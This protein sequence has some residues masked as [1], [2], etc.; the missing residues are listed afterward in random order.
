MRSCPSEAV[1]KG[2]EEGC[3][4]EAV[5]KGDQGGVYGQEKGVVRKVR[6]TRG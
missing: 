2:E 1:G 4:G 3:Q 5:D 6:E